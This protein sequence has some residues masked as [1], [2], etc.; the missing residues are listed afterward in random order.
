M[1]DAD[2]RPS[3]QPST[4]E[5]LLRRAAAV[6]ALPADAAVVLVGVILKV[7][8]LDPLNII[9]SIRELIQRDLGHG[10]RRGRAGCGAISCSAPSSWCRSG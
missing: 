10:L 5:P 4:L 3:P 9:E 1:I 8:G 2:R 6:G 7:L